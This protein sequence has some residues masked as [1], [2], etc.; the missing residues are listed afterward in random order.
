MAAP[1]FRRDQ[2]KVLRLLAANSKTNLTQLILSNQVTVD[3]TYAVPPRN[4]LGFVR[5]PETN[6]NVAAARSGWVQVKREYIRTL[7]A[8][9]QV[10]LI[11]AEREA[12]TAKVGLWREEDLARAR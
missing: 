12:Q 5:M 7:P 9:D 4:A 8:Q 11:Q 6:V 3:V 2:P 1:E 10:A